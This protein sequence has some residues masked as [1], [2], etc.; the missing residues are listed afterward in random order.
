MEFVELTLNTIGVGPTDLIPLISTNITALTDSPFRCRSF[1][2]LS[3]TRQSIIYRWK[4]SSNSRYFK[5]GMNIYPSNRYLIAQNPLFLRLKSVDAPSILHRY[6]I[7]GPSFRWSIDG[8]T[9]EDWWRILGGRGKEKRT[10]L[11]G[12]KPVAGKKIDLYNNKIRPNC[13]L[14]GHGLHIAR[15]I[16]LGVEHRPSYASKGRVSFY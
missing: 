6:S 7:D 9:M 11:Q 8:Q 1:R 12:R 14:K 15:G 4:N 5:T 2:A 13:A 16:A 10:F 3:T